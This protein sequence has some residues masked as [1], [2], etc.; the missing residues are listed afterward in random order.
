MM[1]ASEQ[2][3]T[4]FPTSFH[5]YS[6]RTPHLLP[7][8]LGFPRNTRIFDEVTRPP[9]RGAKETP[10]TR[11]CGPSARS[12]VPGADESQS[13]VGCGMLTNYVAANQ[14]ERRGGLES[15]FVRGRPSVG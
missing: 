7:A 4:P 8:D 6:T 10:T 14:L 12:S 1:L 5:F 15:A 2:T 13:A 3:T 9:H 11:Y